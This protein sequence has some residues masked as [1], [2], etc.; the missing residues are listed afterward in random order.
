MLLLLKKTTCIRK[1][2]CLT[3]CFWLTLPFFR[4][5]DP[6]KNYFQR[7]GKVERKFVITKN[8]C[9]PDI[10]PIELNLPRNRKNL[11]VAHNI[12]PS[13]SAPQRL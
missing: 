10:S 7:D 6:S 1:R 9:H 12:S 11:N 3:R 13:V 2:N 8:P 5:K 4:L